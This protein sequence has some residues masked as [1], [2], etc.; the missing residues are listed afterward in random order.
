MRRRY[1]KFDAKIVVD[2]FDDTAKVTA[3]N[4]TIVFGMDGG[5]LA[6]IVSEEY[7]IRSRGRWKHDGGS[8]G[9]T[10]QI[11]FGSDGTVRSDSDDDVAVIHVE[12]A[13]VKLASM[14]KRDPATQKAL[15]LAGT[16]SILAWAQS[17]RKR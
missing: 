9:P 12:G 14:V 1:R 15:G 7:L 16:M 11:V 2:V 3:T 5:S 17:R 6:A 4:Y 13:A 8:Y 10:A